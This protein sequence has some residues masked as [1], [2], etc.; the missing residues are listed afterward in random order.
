[1]ETSDE[2]LE[3][4]IGSKI[5]F[6]HKE[7]KMVTGIFKGFHPCHGCGTRKNCKGYVLLENIEGDYKEYSH[8]DKKGFCISFGVEGRKWKVEEELKEIRLMLNYIETTNQK[9]Y[10][11][12]KKYR[13]GQRIRIKLANSYFD[14][15]IATIT[16]A[17]KS[18]YKLKFDDHYPEY[19]FNEEAIELI[20]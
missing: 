20:D 2:V 5:S 9:P 3:K 18:N 1:M 16:D 17:L 4:C 15:K 13:L 19:W 12:R 8:K 6:Y 10:D 11:Q 7:N 14:G